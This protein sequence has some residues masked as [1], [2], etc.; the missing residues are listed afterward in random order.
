MTNENYQP[1]RFK[2]NLVK[3]CLRLSAVVFVGG[4][5][6]LATSGALSK[7]GGPGL[8]D[9]ANTLQYAGMMGTI[10]GGYSTVVLGM[11][12]YSYD[13]PKQY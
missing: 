3:N 6:A 13:K 11:R 9:L 4:L 7:N 1:S 12:F 2:Y 5:G 8:E 10:I